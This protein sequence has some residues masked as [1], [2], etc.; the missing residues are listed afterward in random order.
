MSTSATF[1]CNLIAEPE[2]LHS[3]D[4]K[5]FAGYCVAISRRIEIE[6]GE[7][8]D[9]ELTGQSVTTGTAVNHVYHSAERVV[10][11]RRLRNVA[12]RDGET[13]GK[14]AKQVVTVGDRFGEVGVSLKYGAARLERQTDPAATTEN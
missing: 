10:V 14:R 9:G 1:A 5:P 11:N 13:G 6:A 3:R 8:V 12:W 4:G 7:W 2:L